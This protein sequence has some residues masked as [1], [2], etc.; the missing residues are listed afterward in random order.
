MTNGDLGWIALERESEVDATVPFR[1]QVHGRDGRHQCLVLG[2]G[3][4][5]MSDHRS[6]DEPDRYHDGFN[7]G[8]H[9]LPQSHP[10]DDIGGLSR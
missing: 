7:P 8:F 5:Q 9:P 4:Q 2:P 1:E 3:D 6:G 10:P